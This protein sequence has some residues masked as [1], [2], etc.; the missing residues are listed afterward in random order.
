MLELFGNN[1]NM[2][3]T[4]NFN[5]QNLDFPR[6]IVSLI[7]RVISMLNKKLFY[8]RPS[9]SRFFSFFYFLFVF[10]IF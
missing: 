3:E 2:S 9:S 10:V 7:L 6:K 1:Y 8:D 5:F 4:E